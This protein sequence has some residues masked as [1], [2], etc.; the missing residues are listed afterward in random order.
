MKKRFPEKKILTINY[1][2]LRSEHEVEQYFEKAEIITFSTT[3]TRFDWFEKLTKFSKHKKTIGYCHHVENWKM[4]LK[5][6]AEVEI[7]NSI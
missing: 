1:F 3:F 4:A 6:N 2:D 5:I 7:V